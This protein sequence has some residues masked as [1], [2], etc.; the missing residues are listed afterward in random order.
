MILYSCLLINKLNDKN[1]QLSQYLEKQGT[2]HGV[3]RKIICFGFSLL[4]Q[5]IIDLESQV[6]LYP[7]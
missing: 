5:L 4:P 2:I 7:N 6:S 1:A 3:Y